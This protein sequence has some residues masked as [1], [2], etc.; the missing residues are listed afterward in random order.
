[1]KTFTILTIKNS[2]ST[3]KLK[4]E[5]EKVLNEKTQ[6]GYEIVSVDFGYTI[7]GIPVA[8]ITICR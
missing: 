8:Y 7:W 2:W 3:N 1:M 6:E 5:V 4:I